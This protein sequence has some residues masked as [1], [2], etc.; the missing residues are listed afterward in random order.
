MSATDGTTARLLADLADEQDA[1]EEIVAGLDAAGWSTPT[2]SPGWSVFDQIAHLTFFDEAAALAIE[3]PEA[4]GAH[5]EDLAGA[6]TE[7]RL[8]EATIGTLRPLDPAALM[9]RW[10][11]ARRDL[12]VAASS[13]DPDARIPWYGPSMGLRSFLTARLMETWAHGRDVADALEVSHPAT[14][15]LRHVVRLGLLTR[16]WSYANRGLPVPDAE[17]RL[18]LVAPSGA[19][20]RLGPDEAEEW[21]RGSAE[22]FCLVVTQRRHVDDTGLETTPLARDWL[23]RAQCFA[24]P[25]TDGPPPGGR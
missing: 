22:E 2:P 24:G 15:R 11:G 1:L 3:D 19:S 7:G 23:L 12:L 13:L 21:V 17:V 16:G 9:A 10:R 6:M 25:P 14:D 4:F 20:W 5:L 8:D 18:E